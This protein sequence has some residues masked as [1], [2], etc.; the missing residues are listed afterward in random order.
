MIYEVDQWLLSLTPGEGPT[1]GD[2]PTGAGSL[3]RSERS[4]RSATE[5]GPSTPLRY[6]EVSNTHTG[7]VCVFL[8]TQP[9]GLHRRPGGF[10]SLTSFAK[11]TKSTSGGAFTRGG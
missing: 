7:G 9:T 10:A 5:L 11:R 4:E 6:Q 2:R 8:V 3:L 1:G